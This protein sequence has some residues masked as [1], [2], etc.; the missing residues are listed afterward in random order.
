[1]P[2][3][4]MRRVFL[5]I[6]SQQNKFEFCNLL[7]ETQPVGSLAIYLKILRY[8]LLND[9]DAIHQ[10]YV[11]VIEMLESLSCYTLAFSYCKS[12]LNIQ[13]QGFYLQFSG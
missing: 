3:L 8:S 13:N 10:S 2:S 12:L 11:N 7:R 4:C 6:L 9:D 5:D 1:M